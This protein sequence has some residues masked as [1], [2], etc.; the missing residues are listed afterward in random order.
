MFPLDISFLRFFGHVQLVGNPRVDPGHA[1]KILYISLAW[2]RLGI[3]PGGA[4]T[5]T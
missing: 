3:P 2:E 4:A 1:G 5:K